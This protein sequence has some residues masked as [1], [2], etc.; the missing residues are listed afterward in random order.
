MESIYGQSDI[1]QQI[2]SLQDGVEIVVGTPGR[3]KDLQQRGKLQLGDLQT[4][5]LDETD[6]MLDQ[7]FQ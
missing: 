1:Y 6:Q 5:I 7:G 4:F 3:I 2:R